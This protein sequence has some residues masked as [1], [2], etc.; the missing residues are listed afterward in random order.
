L[1]P[2]WILYRWSQNQCFTTSIYF[3][4][5]IRFTSKID[6][7][8]AYYGSV[9]SWCYQKYIKFP[10]SWVNGNTMVMCSGLQIFFR[11]EIFNMSTT[12]LASAFIAINAANWST[13]LLLI[14]QLISLCLRACHP[15]CRHQ[16]FLRLTL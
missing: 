13:G 11:D 4:S 2:I 16:K 9:Y 15:E 1:T 10:I 7:D 12:F 8:Q 6:D 14:H 5:K 3:F